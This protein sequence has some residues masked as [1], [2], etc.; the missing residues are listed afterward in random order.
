MSS[1]KPPAIFK[2]KSVSFRPTSDGRDAFIKNHISKLRE[3]ATSRRELRLPR[4]SSYIEKESMRS[5]TFTSATTK[6]PAL[7]RDVDEEVWYELT[8]GNGGLFFER[9]EKVPNF[10]NFNFFSFFKFS[11]IV[12]KKSSIRFSEIFFENPICM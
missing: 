6:K 12:R 2:P 8:D 9:M 4:D 1:K 7:L 11:V 10:D 5:Q 3:S